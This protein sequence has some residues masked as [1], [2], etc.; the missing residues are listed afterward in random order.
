MRFGKQRDGA[1]NYT[2]RDLIR[3]FENHTLYIG[4]QSS[5]MWVGNGE[6]AEFIVKCLDAKY[7]ANKKKYVDQATKQ[8]RY[9][10][11]KETFLRELLERIKARELP[12][13]KKAIKRHYDELE[14]CEKEIKRT[15]NRIA[16]LEKSIDYN[17]NYLDNW[18]PMLE[19]KVKSVYRY[20]KCFDYDIRGIVILMEGDEQGAYWNVKE[21]QNNPLILK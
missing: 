6:E 14:K 13:K 18:V 20:E 16:N 2:V 19:R 11:E 9:V 8:Y 5:Y 21:Y 4:A 10:V 12:D 15:E 3:R 7:K 17:T 1:T